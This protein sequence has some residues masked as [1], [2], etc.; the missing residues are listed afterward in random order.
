MLLGHL[1]MQFRLIAPWMCFQRS[2][3]HS[4]PQSHPSY[5]TH[6]PVQVIQGTNQGL[7]LKCD[8][9]TRK[10]ATCKT[11]AVAVARSCIFAMRGGFIFQW[12]DTCSVC[13]WPQYAIR[14]SAWWDITS[15]ARTGLSSAASRHTKMPSSCQTCLPC[16][17]SLSQVSRTICEWR[18]GSHGCQTHGHTD[19]RRRDTPPRTWSFRAGCGARRTERRRYAIWRQLSAIPSRS[20]TTRSTLASM[21]CQPAFTNIGRIQ[22][23]QSWPPRASLGSGQRPLASPTAW[24]CVPSSRPGDPDRASRLTL[25]PTLTLTL[26]LSTVGW[27]NVK[28]QGWWQRQR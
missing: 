7:T 6:L 4:Q 12:I 11:V 18:R 19:W 13:Y 1:M 23:H 10:V 27:H 2:Y 3:Q 26:A 16:P 14:L 22:K 15:D 28:G 17:K 5:D 25:T 21:N 8:Y 9:Q 20:I 24:E